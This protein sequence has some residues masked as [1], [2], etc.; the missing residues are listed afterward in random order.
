MAS[1]GSAVPEF[2]KTLKSSK[3]VNIT[4]R[5]MTRFF[6][7]IED[8]ASFVIDSSFRAEGGVRVFK[9]MKSCSIVDLVDVLAKLLGVHEYSVNYVGMRPGEK[10]HEDLFHDELSGGMTSEHAPQFSQAELIQLLL[11]LVESEIS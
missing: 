5:E 4:H 10:L 8:A 2:I 11:P 7:R 6:M 3:R 1:R 9:N